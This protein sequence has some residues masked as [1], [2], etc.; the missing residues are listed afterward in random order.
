MTQLSRPHK[1]SLPYSPLKQSQQLGCI[2]PSH[3]SNICKVREDSSIDMNDNLEPGAPRE[4]P[5]NQS[6]RYD[7]LSYSED[8]LIKSHRFGNIF[9]IQNKMVGKQLS[10][11]RPLTTYSSSARP[12]REAWRANPHSDRWVTVRFKKDHGYI[13]HRPGR[14]GRILLPRHQFVVVK[15]SV[16][17]FTSNTLHL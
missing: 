4:N 15:P 12:T 8:T 10:I 2:N 17:R 1:I 3:R 7:H 11:H 5:A 9:W 6:N 14:I 16:F 13:D